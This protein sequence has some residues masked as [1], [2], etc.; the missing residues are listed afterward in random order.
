MCF[1]GWLNDLVLKAY[2]H[3]FITGKKYQLMA[4]IDTDSAVDLRMGPVHPN[5][6]W[7]E[8]VLPDVTFLSIGANQ[9]L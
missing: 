6:F 7:F 8:I 3:L 2:I 5:A 9:E 1:W 4:G